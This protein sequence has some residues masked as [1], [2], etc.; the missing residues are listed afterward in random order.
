MTTNSHEAVDTQYVIRL[1]VTGADVY[2]VNLDR[3]EGGSLSEAL[4]FT[5]EVSADI[6]LSRVTMHPKF[7]H[8]A[9]S[10]VPVLVPP[11]G[12]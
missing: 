9:A 10:V 3:S 6:F 1:W 8:H 12:L 7:Q 2:F 11:F 4:R 5:T